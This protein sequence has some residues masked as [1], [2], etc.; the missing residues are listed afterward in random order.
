MGFKG[1]NTPRDRTVAGEVVTM[2]RQALAQLTPPCR[3]VLSMSWFIA[4]SAAFTVTGQRLDT[5]S[6]GFFCEV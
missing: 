4:R 2:E 1:H 5:V 3:R 6:I